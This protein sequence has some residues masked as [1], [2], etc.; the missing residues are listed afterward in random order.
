MLFE[1]YDPLKVSKDGGK[2]ILDEGNIFQVINKD[3]ALDLASLKEGLGAAPFA[4]GSTEST[5][6]FF[7]VI[8][9]GYSVRRGRKRNWT[10]RCATESRRG[11]ALHRVRGRGA[12]LVGTRIRREGAVGV[13]VAPAARA[14]TFV[15]CGGLPPLSER[16][17]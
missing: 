3:G 17:Y 13:A 7:F 5:S 10:G 9:T 16:R 11:R 6:A 2:N 4:T 12:Q 15:E 8:G 14:M 1:K